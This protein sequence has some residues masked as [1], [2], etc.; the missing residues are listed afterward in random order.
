MDKCVYC[1]PLNDEQHWNEGCPWRGEYAP[2][3]EGEVIASLRSSLAAVEAER[4]S[5]RRTYDEMQHE[6]H[7]LKAKYDELHDQRFAEARKA[8]ALKARAEAAEALVAKISANHNKRLREVE[9]LTDALE[10]LR[11]YDEGGAM[12]S[13]IDAALTASQEGKS[14]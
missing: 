8:D 12:S 1:G 7:D 9:R 2:P 10:E 5:A 14:R 13:I 6:L 11:D 3:S 4:D